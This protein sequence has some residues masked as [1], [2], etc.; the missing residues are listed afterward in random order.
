MKQVKNTGEKFNAGFFHGYITIKLILVSLAIAVFISYPD[1][2]FFSIELSFI[3]E[4]KFARLILF[5]TFRYFYFSALIW[6]ML[7]HNLLNVKL[8]SIGKRFF[9]TVLIGGVGFFVFM[10]FSLILYP[11]KNCFTGFLL[12][13]FSIITVFCSLLG[14]V[15]HLYNE[16][17]KKEKEI[18]QLKIENLQSR[19]VA[20][21][22]Q[23]NPHFFFNSLNGLS[24][25]IR[26]KN[27]EKSIEYVNKLSDV[28]RY[29]LQSDKKSIVTLGEELECVTALSYMMEVRFANKL[30]FNIVVKEEHKNL[31]IPVLSLLPLI[32]NV[33]VHNII[34]SEHKMEV[35]IC[36]NDKMELSV[37][38]PIFPKLDIPN[39]NGTGLKNLESRF[40]LL[41]NKQIRIIND[42]ER[43]T[44]YLPLIKDKDENT[45]S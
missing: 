11:E 1:F 32:D 10:G 34:D 8:E 15:A 35:V 17:R 22:N 30:V 25:L 27:E 36:L 5:F 7:R 31:K 16:F 9:Q 41:L 43:F 45:D 37:S 12:F 2:S 38:N 13:Q 21:T 42:G 29:V 28:F 40:L 6:L 20:L 18:E 44:I 26:K 23:I 19:Y 24:F 14:H 3:G 33:V 39:T 4:S